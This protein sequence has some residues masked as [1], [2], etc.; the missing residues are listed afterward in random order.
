LHG[1]IVFVREAETI[2]GYGFT[3]QAPN[4]WVI[5][6][7]G[8][9][10]EQ[11][12][13]DRGGVGLHYPKA[14]P[15]HIVFASVLTDPVGTEQIHHVQLPPECQDETY[16]GTPYCGN[17]RYSPSGEYLAYDY[18]EDLCG[19]GLHIADVHTGERVVDIWAGTHRFEWLP[20]GRALLHTGHCEGSRV[21]VFDPR[22][23][24]LRELGQVGRRVFAPDGATFAEIVMP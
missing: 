11:L 1:R 21:S 4:L 18:G 14:P 17:Y 23:Q 12:T 13:F 19:R 16:D 5:Y 3:H 15:P 2:V 24:H 9:G 20:D 7:D 22:A 8:S 10:L 6:P